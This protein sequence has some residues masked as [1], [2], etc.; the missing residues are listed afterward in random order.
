VVN[1]DYHHRNG[2]SSS[3]TGDDDGAM[4]HHHKKGEKKKKEGIFCFLAPISIDAW[5]RLFVMFC[6]LMLFL[7]QFEIFY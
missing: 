4:H 1:V 5:T 2:S 3:S 6:L 7:N